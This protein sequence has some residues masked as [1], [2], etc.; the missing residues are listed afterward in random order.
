M[1]NEVKTI[2]AL[3]FRPN[4]SFKFRLSAKWRNGKK[5][6]RRRWDWERR[7]REV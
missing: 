4:F 1:P 5:R 7:W 2:F 6:K 3:I